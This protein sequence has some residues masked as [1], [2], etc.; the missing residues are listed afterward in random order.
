MS[1]DIILAPQALEDLKALKAAL[2]ATV[3]DAMQRHL[4]QEPEKISRSRI[5]R[6]RG[7]SQPQYRLRVAE[8][9]IFYDVIVAE[10]RVEVL[11]VVPKSETEKWLAQ[12]GKPQA[13]PESAKSPSP[14]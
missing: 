6:L 11:A 3:K 13:P 12:F 4:E 2:R 5:K 9:R 14:K 8:V 7:L 1:F 10:G